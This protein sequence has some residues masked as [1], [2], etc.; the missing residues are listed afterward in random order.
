MEY[1]SVD[2]V[3]EAPTKPT[4]H[5]M[6]SPK[7]ASSITSRDSEP[8][9]NVAGWDQRAKSL[10]IRGTLHP[11]QSPELTSMTDHGSVQ[12]HGIASAFKITVIA[13]SSDS[14]VKIDNFS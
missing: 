7:P 12:K 14:I 5:V 11:Q 2:K 10:G 9:E 6:N 8:K 4:S 3:E 13:K 1:P